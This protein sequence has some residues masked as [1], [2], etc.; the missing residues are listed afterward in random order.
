MDYRYIKRGDTRKIQWRKDKKQKWKTASLGKC[1]DDDAHQVIATLRREDFRLENFQHLPL[2]H[3]KILADCGFIPQPYN[4]TVCEFGKS[5]ME[6][7]QAAQS[8]SRT[9][10]L[11]RRFIDRQLI[12]YFGTRQLKTVTVEDAEKWYAWRAKNTS[13]A[14]LNR[15]VRRAKQVFSKAVDYG[16]INRNPFR[17]LKGGQSVNRKRFEFV[18]LQ[19][20][21]KVFDQCESQEWRTILALSRFGGL[22]VDSELC[23]LRW[24]C[25]DFE[26]G[27]IRIIEHKTAEREMP[28]WPEI[29]REL[30]RETD[31]TGF[32]V[33]TCREK[34]NLDDGL[35][36]LM[37]RAG[38]KVWQKLWQNQ[39][40][41]RQ[42]ELESM[43]FPRPAVC[44][45]FGNS[46]EVARVHYLHGL[47]GDFRRAIST[48]TKLPK[49]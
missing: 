18:D 48:E 22:R 42:S 21:Q 13:P 28:M 12:D 32:V 20:M 10:D 46:C 23:D 3:Q 27:S 49:N 34:C 39:R 44:E 25:I 4:D 45:W 16:I 35:R 43:G 2:E 40:A 47:D 8:K 15:D 6:F 11:M 5:F 30:E 41:T 31:R 33:K 37:G 9:I 19:R 1:S 29:R 17:T 7:Y 38:V 36:R 14:T 26:L 24:D